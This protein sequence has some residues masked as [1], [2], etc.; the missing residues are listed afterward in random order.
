MPEVSSRIRCEVVI[1][2]AGADV[3]SDRGVGHAVV[4]RRSV[5]IPVEV[6]GVLLEQVRPHDHADVAESEEELVILID[7]H[8]RRRDVAIH[9]ADIQH[10]AGIDVSVDGPSVIQIGNLPH[11]AVK[12]K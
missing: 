11:G 12:R 9:Y 10:L 8:Q 5:G 3:D 6:N 7:R 1:G 2:E 4:E